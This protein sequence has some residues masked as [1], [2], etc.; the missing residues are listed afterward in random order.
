MRHVPARPVIVGG[1]AILTG[2]LAA[3][4]PGLSGA[5]TQVGQATTYAA[6]AGAYGST[7]TVGDV[8]KS[9]RSAVVTLGCTTKRGVTHNDTTDHSTVNSAGRVGSVTNHTATKALSG[10]GI[11]SVS[12][13]TTSALDLAGGVITGKAVDA[14]STVSGGDSTS[15]AGTTHFTDLKVA[16]KPVASTPKPNTVYRLPGVGTLK[17]NVQH[18]AK[19]ASERS[20]TVEALT[21]TAA[22]HNTAGLAAGTRVVVGHARAALSNLVSNPLAGSS[23][24]TAIETGS[25]AKSAPSFRQVMPC[26]GTGGRT[27]RN[28]GGDVAAGSAL[29][30]GNVVSTA[31]AKTATSGATGATRSHVTGVALLG[32]LVKARA[33]TAVAHI[34]GKY[35]DATVSEAGSGIAGLVIDGKAYKG[36]VAPNTKIDLGVG[37]LWLNRLEKSDNKVTVHM[38]DLH[39]AKA[40]D[41]LPKGADLV[42][43]NATVGLHR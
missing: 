15:T 39:L 2:A 23:Y 29:K 30:T 34:A 10:G 37:T 6:S 8:A 11:E 16:G 36:S 9:G 20:L 28:S 13:S 4:M 7:V 1:A 27:L 26:E 3:T 19:T 32:K 35:G 33:I 5:T 43:G 17:L 18:D 12:R 42:V 40:R 21:L 38:I 14:T 24:G 25:T 41:G 22:K 31:T